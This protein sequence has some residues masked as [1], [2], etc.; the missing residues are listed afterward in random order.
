[1]YLC[2][3][4]LD[5]NLAHL[6]TCVV[7]TCVIFNPT[8]KGEKANRFGQHL[9]QIARESTLKMTAAPAD[10]RRLAA[11]AVEEGFEIIVAAGGDGTVNE[12]LNGLGD[13]PKGIEC[14]RLG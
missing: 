5:S 7:R 13:A 2:F 9:E 4:V 3:F 12:V 11:E 10:A 6:K 14:A 1:M 8:A